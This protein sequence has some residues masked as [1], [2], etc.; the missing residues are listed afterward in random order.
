MSK[1]ELNGCK[2]I[3][4]PKILKKR[5]MNNIIEILNKKINFKNDYKKINDVLEIS[6]LLKNI[7]QKEF[8]S[9]FGHVSNRYLSLELGKIINGWIKKNLSKHLGDKKASLHFPTKIDLKK[10]KYLSKKQFCIYFRCVRPYSKTD[11]GKL[12]R[13]VDFW[14]LLKEHEKP[15]APFKIN[16]I[17]RIW[18]P[19]FGCNKKNSLKFYKKSHLD[20]SIK[21]K[22]FKKNGVVKPKINNNNLK[23]KKFSGL[24]RNFNNEAIL[25]RD[26]IVHFA[27][28]NKNKNFIRYSVECS[29]VTN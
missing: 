3:K 1:L 18:I 9:M 17:Y 26:D 6:N 27:P 16:N 22:F 8:I 10:N 15:L 11:V 28:M 7:S 14:N 19:L 2:I 29:V 4:F 24:I 23:N 5:I 20:K 21:S 25:F 13:D 12:H